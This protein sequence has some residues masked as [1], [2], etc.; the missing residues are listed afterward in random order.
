[1]SRSELMNKLHL[2]DEKNF[3]QNYIQAA[4]QQNLIERTIPEK[5][6]TPRQKYRITPQGANFLK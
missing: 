1:M 5:P 3:R 6:N 4:L 2:N